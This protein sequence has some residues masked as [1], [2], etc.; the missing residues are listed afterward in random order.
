MTLHEVVLEKMSKEM[1]RP[2]RGQD[3]HAFVFLIALDKI[4]VCGGFE[5]KLK[6]CKSLRNTDGETDAG[7]FP[8]RKA[9]LSLSLSCELRTL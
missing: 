9:Q 8:I 6:M 7:H 1:S 4:Q 3:S 2:T 5:K